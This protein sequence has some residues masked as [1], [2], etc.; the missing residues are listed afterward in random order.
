MARSIS[1][2]RRKPNLVD[3][4]VK[5]RDGKTGFRFGAAANFDGAFTTFAVVPN[6]GVKSKSVPDVYAGNVGNQFREDVRFL[7]DPA[8]YVATAAALVDANPFYLRVEARNPDGTFDAPEAM[9]LVIPPPV[10]PNR[11]I[12]IRGTVPAAGSLATSLEIQLPGQCNDWEILNDGG[13]PLFV[14]FHPTGGEHQV[15][16][17]T[18]AFDAFQQYTTAVSQLFLRGAGGSTTVSTTLTLRN[19]P[20]T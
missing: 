19:N 9:H 12:T 13:A 6:Y 15:L 8:D 14:A 5:K 1:I 16:P 7:F 18:T 2:Y 10:E 4:L 3:L 17:V 20:M 11:A